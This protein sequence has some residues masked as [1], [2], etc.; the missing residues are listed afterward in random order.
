ME[1]LTYMEILRSLPVE[2]NLWIMQ[3]TY[4]EIARTVYAELVKNAKRGSEP[5]RKL[6]EAFRRTGEL[7]LFNVDSLF[8][9]GEREQA[10]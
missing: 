9:E 8:A 4:E 2:V 10:A 5:A 6:I 1:F 3:N 7:L